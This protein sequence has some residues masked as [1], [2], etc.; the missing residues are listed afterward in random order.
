MRLHR[1]LFRDDCPDTE[2]LAEIGPRGWLI[3]TADRRIQFRPVEWNAFLNA[4]ARV[5]VL[6][7]TGLRGVEQA[8]LFVEMLPRIRE[9]A[10]ETPRPFIAQLTRTKVEVLSR[11]LKPKRVRGR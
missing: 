10:A 1:D 2:W 7:T 3:L 11:Q 5:F 6:R 8:Q 4:Q 9:L